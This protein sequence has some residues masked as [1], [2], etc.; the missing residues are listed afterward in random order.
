M[1]ANLAAWLT[2][3]SMA[4]MAKST[5]MI[6]T[7]GRS[8]TRAAPT[9]MPVNAA[10]AIGVSTHPARPELGQQPLGDLEGAAALGDVLAHEEDRAGRAASPRPAPGAA[11]PVHHLGHRRLLDR[12]PET[13][14]RRARGWPRRTPRPRRSSASTAASIAAARVLADRRAHEHEQRVARLPRG[15][16]LF[17]SMWQPGVVHVVAAVPVG[18]RLDQRRALPAPRAGHRREGRR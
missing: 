6:S 2:I 17:G 18:L 8:P 15:Q 1:K 11:L 10:S 9:P 16:D 3:W 5:N 14:P 13:R 7:T 4:S 12:R